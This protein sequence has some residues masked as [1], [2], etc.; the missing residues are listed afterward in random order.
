MSKNYLLDMLSLNCPDR[1]K[2]I[3]QAHDNYQDQIVKAVKEKAD[4]YNYIS[5]KKKEIQ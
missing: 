1:I 5:E 2:E 3:Q 4:I